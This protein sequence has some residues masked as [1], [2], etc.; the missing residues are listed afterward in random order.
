MSPSRSSGDDIENRKLFV[1]RMMYV[2]LL[3]IGLGI[4]WWFVSW[5]NGLISQGGN[6]PY[7]NLEKYE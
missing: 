4:G 5:L 2:G 1:R 3:L 6:N 7:Q